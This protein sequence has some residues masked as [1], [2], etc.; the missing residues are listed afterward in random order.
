[1]RW[2][3]GAVSLSVHG[4]E[5]AGPEGG[6][7]YMEDLAR[8]AADEPDRLVMNGTGSDSVEM[9]VSE[10]LKKVHL[11]VSSIDPDGWADGDAVTPTIG[12]TKTSGRPMPMTEPEAA[13]PAHRPLRAHLWP[14]RLRRHG[15][16]RTDLQQHDR[17][18]TLARRML[19]TDG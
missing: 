7:R 15:G 10:L 12:W 2:L 1:M 13:A 8:W 3:V 5:R 18:R 16:R 11:Y 4:S 9:P 17:P 14:R 19:T 6:V